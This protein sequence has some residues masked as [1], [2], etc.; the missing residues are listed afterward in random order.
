[1]GNLTNVDKT[2]DPEPW[3]NDERLKDAFQVGTV[4]RVIKLIRKLAETLEKAPTSPM[5]K[6]VSIPMMWESVKELKQ[7]NFEDLQNACLEHDAYQ[8][9]SEKLEEEDIQRA[10]FVCENARRE[11]RARDKRLV[12][13]ISLSDEDEPTASK[14]HKCGSLDS[15]VVNDE[16]TCVISSPSHMSLRPLLRTHVC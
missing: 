11:K 6:T 5:S 15:D 13:E 12:E 4:N 8:L 14:E 1:M 2:L 9:S 7:K 10:K 3:A 16:G